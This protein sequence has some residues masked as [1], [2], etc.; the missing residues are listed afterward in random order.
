MADVK[1]SFKNYAIILIILNTVI[2]ILEALFP[3]IVDMFGL[4]PPK[5]IAEPWIIVT[6]MF[7]H[8]GF[9]HLLYNMFAL[10][11][12]GIVLERIIGSE[13]FL[14]GYILSGIFAGL[15]TIFMYPLSLSIGASGAIY[16]IIGILSVLRPRL[17]IYLG[18]P[19]P[20]LF[21]AVVYVFFDV[22]GIITGVNPDNIAYGAHVA[23]FISGVLFGLRIKDKFNEEKEIR[24]EISSEFDDEELDKWEEEYMK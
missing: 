17:M 5:F 7:L 15:A 11:L 13:K 2:L 6:S 8:S 19:L 1:K 20:M 21:Y 10:G 16:G 4:Y 18:V 23:G 14:I 3:V 12:F 24:A 22:V 9:E